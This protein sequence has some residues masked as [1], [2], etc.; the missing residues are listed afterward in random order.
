MISIPDLT[1][2]SNQ[3][4]MSVAAG[5]VASFVPG[6]D[7]LLPLPRYVH[8]AAAGAATDLY[9]RGEIVPSELD[10]Q[11]VMCAA[12]GALGGYVIQY[13]RVLGYI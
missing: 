7:T 9:C 1:D 2:C 4:Y 3:R 5:A 6:V 13:L 12:G 10:K 11:L 8:W